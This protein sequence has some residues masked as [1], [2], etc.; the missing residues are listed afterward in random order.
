[1]EPEKLN[2]GRNRKDER[3][4]GHTRG[5]W[6]S[7]SHKNRHEKIQTIVAYTINWDVASKEKPF[8]DPNL[9]RYVLHVRSNTFKCVTCGKKFEFIGS[10][11][12]SKRCYEDYFVAKAQKK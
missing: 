7:V 10:A 1:M 8:N 4:F 2:F 6:G 9:L 5:E 3:N 12:C 11:F